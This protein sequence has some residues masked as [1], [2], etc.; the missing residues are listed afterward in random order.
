MGFLGGE[1]YLQHN[2]KSKPEACT[3]ERNAMCEILGCAGSRSFAFLTFSF[4]FYLNW[5][6]YSLVYSS[7]VNSNKADTGII[8]LFFCVNY[9]ISLFSIV[10]SMC[11]PLR[12][13]VGCVAE[14]KMSS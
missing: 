7:T 13:L 2:K 8:S 3:V 4:S 10:L 1:K 14:L 6:V 5:P 12:E 9:L 11:Y